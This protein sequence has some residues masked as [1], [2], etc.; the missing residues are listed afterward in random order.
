MT[1]TQLSKEIRSATANCYRNGFHDGAAFA[2]LAVAVVLV[3]AW[4]LFA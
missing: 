2:L 3:L 1:E 4:R